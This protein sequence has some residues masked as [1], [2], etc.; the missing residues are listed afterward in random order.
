MPTAKPEFQ[1]DGS[2]DASVSRDMTQVLFSSFSSNLDFFPV[3]E[4]TPSR[5]I[6]PAAIVGP[7]APAAVL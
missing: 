6:S 7:K 4:P 2:G 3:T 1:A 5:P